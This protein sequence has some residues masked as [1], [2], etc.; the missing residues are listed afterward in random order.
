MGLGPDS[1]CAA[2]GA[3]GGMGVTRQRLRDAGYWGSSLSLPVE[4][5]FWQRAHSGGVQSL[6]S[7]CVRRSAMLYGRCRAEAER[8]RG[9]CSLSLLGETLV[10]LGAHSGGVKPRFSLRGQR[11]TRLHGRRLAE[12]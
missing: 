4:G 11:R 10:W 9:G 7:L 2:E 12:A 8:R 3:P 1:A 5:W 6:F